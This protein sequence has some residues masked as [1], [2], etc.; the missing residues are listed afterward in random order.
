MSARAETAEQRLRIFSAL[1]ARNRIVGILRIGVPS[2]GVVVFL[3]VAAQILIGGIAND[4]GIGRVTVNGDQVTVDTPTYAGI[5]SNGDTYKISAEG[6]HTALTDM[7]VIDLSH[8]SFAL[9]KPDGTQ[10]SA[11]SETAALETIRQTVTVPGTTKVSDSTG[12]RGTLDKVFIDWPRQMMKA[13]GKVS[14]QMNDGA[15][16][17]ADTLDYS[18]K[19]AIWTFK[20][21]TLTVPDIP[22]DDTP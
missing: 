8:V 19:T 9:V 20:N 15:T 2:I 21:A 4:F 12:N 14:M 5:M 11:Q 1:G 18:A 22:G 17:V 16:I 10:M 7:S 3:G 13:S 6:A